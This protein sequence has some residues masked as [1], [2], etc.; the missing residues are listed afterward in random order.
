MFQRLFQR[1]SL[2]RLSTLFL[3]IALVVGAM[4]FRAFDFSAAQVANAQSANVSAGLPRTITV[5]GEGKVKIKPDTARAQIGVEVMKSSVK[6]ASDANKAT[7]EAVLEALKAQGIA[8]KDIQTSGFSIFAE[9]YGPEGPLPENQT[10]YRVSNNVSVVIRDLEKVGAVLD[11]AIEAGS[12]NIYGIEFG[13][14]NTDAVE[15]E[16]RK[17][18]VADARAKAEELGELAGVTVSGVV[19]VSEVIGSGGGYYNA[20]NFN[21]LDRGM[22]GGGTPIS[23][24]ELDLTLQL[25]V[26]YAI[27]E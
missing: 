23:P 13:L 11:A 20:S 17:S 24:G 4:T 19:S 27:A 3:L 12:N 21:Q 2:N 15:A 7:L 1:Q 10:N 22:G 8:E 25:Q 5:V 14:D 6:E 16:A 18:A 26:V 9:R